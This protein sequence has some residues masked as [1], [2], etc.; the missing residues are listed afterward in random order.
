MT[1]LLNILLAMPWLI[2]TFALTDEDDKELHTY[3]GIIPSYAF[4]RNLAVLQAEGKKG[5]GYSTADLF[6][7]E[8]DFLGPF[9]MLIADVF[10]FAGL[11]L[12]MELYGSRI[13]NWLQSMSYREDSGPGTRTDRAGGS[14]DRKIGRSF[15]GGDALVA[16]N[17]IKVYSRR[18]ETFKAVDDVSM[19]LKTGNVYGLLGPNGAGKTTTHSILT[20][21]V[22]PTKGKSYVDGF[23]I[24]S[25][26]VECQKRMGLCTQ[27]DRLFERLSAKETLT[28]YATL[29]GVPKAEI[30]RTEVAII[31]AV[32]LTKKADSMCGE[33]SG[34][35][36]RKLS[37]ASSL[38][39]QCPVVFLDEPTTGLDTN[40]R[41]QIWRYIEAEKKRRAILLTSHSMEE[42]D[43]LSDTI[44][45]LV[46]G[47]MRAEGTSAAL[48]AKY[49]TGYR[50]HMK[51]KEQDSIS[52]FMKSNFEGATIDNQTTTFSVWNVPVTDIAYVG[53]LFREI[54]KVKDAF[55]ITDFAIAQANLED[56]FLQ[57]AQEQERE[58]H[59][60]DD[61]V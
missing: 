24:V 4:Y 2:T 23:N 33:Y 28:L 16:S 32:G 27:F 59:K 40:A 61:N 3:L 57:F 12:L 1:E 35:N 31:N 39:G 9:L 54:L 19:K 20:G 56:V 26:P 46:N 50:V 43:R 48:K 53:R 30:K 36:K 29:R 34:G 22:L 7:P 47:K 49:G 10:I 41:R 44:G 18:G 60:T 6:D 38:V 42:A 52:E 17:I 25:Q 37:I 45:I 15:E 8:K 14:G 13:T 58:E 5:T 21:L 11:L 51:S 55:G